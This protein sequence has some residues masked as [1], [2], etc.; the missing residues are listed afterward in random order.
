LARKPKY[1]PIEGYT[2]G[3][4]RQLAA[5]RVMIYGLPSSPGG[6]G[7]ALRLLERDRK[8]AEERRKQ[9]SKAGDESGRGKIGQAG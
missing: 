5:I 9:D 2:E 4:A 7:P 3:E 8:E 6:V 1:V